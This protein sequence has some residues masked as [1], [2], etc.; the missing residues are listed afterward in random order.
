[1]TDAL[2]R[3]PADFILDSY[4]GLFTAFAQLNNLSVRDMLF[5]EGKTAGA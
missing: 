1:M 5:N 4:R 2:G 3:S